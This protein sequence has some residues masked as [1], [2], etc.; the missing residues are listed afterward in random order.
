[1]GYA[2]K[3]IADRFPAQSFNKIDLISNDFIEKYIS[4][5]ILKK[6]VLYLNIFFTLKSYFSSFCF[7][8]YYE[9]IHK[10]IIFYLSQL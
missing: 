6:A 10:S 5:Y 9:I 3:T 1:M 4:L 8:G 2:S 7:G